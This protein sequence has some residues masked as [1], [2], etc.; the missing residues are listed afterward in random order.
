[1]YIL[2]SKQSF[3]EDHDEVVGQRRVEAQQGLDCYQETLCHRWWKVRRVLHCF[4]YLFVALNSDIKRKKTEGKE[5]DLWECVQKR[6]RGRPRYLRKKSKV[7]LHV[8]RLGYDSCDN[9]LK[10]IIIKII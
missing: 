9:F 3:F 4:F 5:A 8:V 2:P 1:M 7:I 10:Q 6:L